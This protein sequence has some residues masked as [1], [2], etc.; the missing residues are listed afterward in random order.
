MCSISPLLYLAS[1]D[2]ELLL[3]RLIGHASFVRSHVHVT[4]HLEPRYVR[5]LCDVISAW[6]TLTAMQSFSLS[7]S[8]PVRRLRFFGKLLAIPF[9]SSRAQFLL[10]PMLCGPLLLTCLRRRLPAP[11]R[12]LILQLSLPFHRLA[13][14]KVIVVKIPEHRTRHRSLCT[15]NVT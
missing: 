7:S 9:E 2:S 10:P 5:C 12:P 8:P 4:A 11:G 6:P 14:Q 15:P 13:F 1:D 3:L